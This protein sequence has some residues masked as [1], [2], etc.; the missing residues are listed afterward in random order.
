M[1]SRLDNALAKAISE[2]KRLKANEITDSLII[3]K[4]Q[5]MEDPIL[6]RLTIAEGLGYGFLNLLEEGK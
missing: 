3:E 5:G 1:K 2:V 6:R 4:L